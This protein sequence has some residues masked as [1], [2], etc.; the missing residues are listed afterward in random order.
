[1]PRIYLDNAATSWPKPPGV[2]ETIADYYR[3]CGAPAGRGVYSEAMEVQ[4]KIDRVRALA[5]NFINADNPS[6]IVFTLNGTDSLNMV[7]NGL[8]KEGDHAIATVT[9]HNSVLR[10]LN[11]LKSTAGVTSDFVECDSTGFVDPERIRAAIKPNTKLIC[12]N[13]ASNVT[14]TIQPIA[15]IIAIAKQ[16]EI[17]VL[18]DAAQTLGHLDI[19][20]QQ[21]D[22]E[23]LAAP[24]HKA[25]L[26]PLGTG[27]LYIKPGAE[28]R[29]VP[30][31]SGGTGTRSFEPT[32]PNDM[33][34]RFESGNLNVG[35]ILALGCAIDF[36][37][38]DHADTLKKTT[39]EFA[40]QLYERL[41]SMSQIEVYGPSEHHKRAPLISFHCDQYDSR[42]FAVMLDSAASV[43]SRPG[44]H[45]APLMHK[46][47][48]TFDKGGTVRLSPGLFNTQDQID[49]TLALIESLA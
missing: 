1:M 46:S 6:T 8:L 30:L 25:L 33:P 21:L 31:R 49:A 27:I 48:G 2:A 16:S 44:L 10:P 36:L 43:Q 28:K 35:G 18:V 24:G 7:I 39:A 45:C 14:G 12:I 4:R 29:L 38:T 40:H 47:I 34:D 22:C 17:P 13:H 11:Q 37:K 23:Y 3:D 19:N 5:A 42:E 15:E 9:E 41:A 32:Q 26:G 20:V